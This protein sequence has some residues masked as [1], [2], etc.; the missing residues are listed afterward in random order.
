MDISIIVLTC[1][2]SFS[3]AYVFCSSSIPLADVAGNF[4]LQDFVF[5]VT[6]YPLTLF[7]KIKTVTY[8][9]LA[10]NWNFS[11]VAMNTACIAICCDVHIVTC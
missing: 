9:L 6:L 3:V 10:I 11:E 7:I 4:L 8:C 1:F 2:K 5:L